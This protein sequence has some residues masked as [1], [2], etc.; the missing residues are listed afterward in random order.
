MVSKLTPSDACLA[1]IKR[2]ESCRLTVYDDENGFPTIGWGH[3]LTPKESFV[4]GVTQACADYLLRCDVQSAANDV[5]T[6]VHVQITQDQFDAL[7]SF[8]FNIGGSRFRDSTLL[9]YLNANRILDAANELLKW[10]HCSGK[11]SDGLESRREAE[12]KLFLIAI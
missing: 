3:K 1:L 4:E 8:V 12:R 10:D 2:F 11:V 7:C 5:N 6:M 9:I